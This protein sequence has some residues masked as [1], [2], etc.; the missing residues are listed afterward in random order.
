MKSLKHLLFLFAVSSYSYANAGSVI[1]FTTEG[2]DY[3]TLQSKI[4]N[5]E[6]KN[7]QQKTDF[8]TV[9][10]QILSNSEIDIVSIPI[11]AKIIDKSIIKMNN[12]EKDS[13]YI[14]FN[15]IF[16]TAVN[17]FNDSLELKYPQLLEKFEKGLNDQSTRE[18]KKCL[19]LCGLSLLSS[20]GS[21]YVDEKDDY[22]YDLFKGKVTPALNEY[23]K[24]RNKEIKQ[25]YSDDADLLIGFDDLYERVVT[26]EDFM[27]QYPDFFLLKDAEFNYTSY[28]STLITGTDNSETFDSETQNL[29]PGIKRLYEKII[30][31]NDG[32]KSTKVISDYYELLKRNDFK[33]PDN[34]DLF[35][36]A[37]NL[38]S[39]VGVQPETR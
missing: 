30:S 34:L 38:I 26:W 21:Y 35:L 33:Q 12:A 7:A 10:N 36:R 4:Q 25:G 22:Y 27:T 16:Y 32:K 3:S 20:E 17:A 6:S 15:Y 2:L 28:L 5:Y 13:T 14:I 8:N 24:I 18:F 31:H 39:M 23:L 19:D 1:G 11:T 37:N 29:Y 9:K